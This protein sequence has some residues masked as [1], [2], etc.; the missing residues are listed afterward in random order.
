M[1]DR[2]VQLARELL[3]LAQPGLVALAHP[4]AGPVADRRAERRREQEEHHAEE[5]VGD[6]AGD[7]LEGGV[8]D[9]DEPHPDRRVAPGPPAQQRVGEEQQPC[10]GEEHRHRSVRRLVG[11]Q[12]RG[13]IEQRGAAE[14]DDGHE[15]RVRATP[16]ER[17]PD[18]QTHDEPRGPP[19]HLLAEN[20][21][22]DR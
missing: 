17:D 1:G 2:V 10:A 14:C 13:G 8:G 4:L 19:D 11:E 21:L 5:H 16:E 20:R 15:Q 12:A 6:G 7:D 18:A 3:A 22:E 9:E